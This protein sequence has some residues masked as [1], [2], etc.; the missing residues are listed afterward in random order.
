MATI[1]A[2]YT[3]HHNKFRVWT[4]T[5][6]GIVWTERPYLRVE[7]GDELAAPDI[8]GFLLSYRT[9]E[10]AAR[11][12]DDFGNDAIVAPEWF[13]ALDLNRHFVK[14]ELL[15]RNNDDPETGEPAILRTWYGVI[16][17]DERDE[18]QKPDESINRTGLQTLQVFGL[19]RLLET[20][21]INSSIVRKPDG[22]T[23]TIGRGLPFNFESRGSMNRRGNSTFAQ[24][25]GVYVFEYLP[26]GDQDSSNSDEFWNASD[27]VQY[28]LKHHRPVDQYGDSLCAWVA[29]PVVGGDLPITFYDITVET[30]RRSVKAVLDELIDRRRGVGYRVYGRETDSAF[31]AVLQVFTF[32]ATAIPLEGGEIPANESAEALFAG[33]S[34]I[35]DS[36]KVRQIATH[37]VDELIVEGAPPTSTFTLRVG[38]NAAEVEELVK[39]WT[40]QQEDDYRAGASGTAEENAAVR[41]RDALKDVFAR[42]VIATEW[43]TTVAVAVESSDPEEFWVALAQS[44][45]IP[46]DVDDDD[47]HDLFLKTDD[48]T[49]AGPLAF[50]VKRFLDLMPLKDDET[51]E[52]RRPF[53]VFAV[54][55]AG[56]ADD[57]EDI[58]AFAE[59]VSAITDEHFNCTT[60]MLPDRLGIHLEVNRPGGQQ[61]IAVDH[62]EDASETSADIDPN[63]AD[64]LHYENLRLTA[65]IEWDDRVTLKKTLNTATGQKRILRI[66]LP[67]M[68]LDFLLPGTVLDVGADSHL[69]ISTT[70]RVL[71]DDRARGRMILEAAAAWYGQ[72]RQAITISY[73]ELHPKLEIGTL[74]TR[75]WGVSDDPINT[76]VTGIHFNARQGTTTL[77][78]AYAEMDFSTFGRG[79]QGRYL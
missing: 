18:A 1:D 21:F 72:V 53:V 54:A 49:R 16:E 3:Y 24:E 7:A 66:S 22:D 28:L 75:L 15:D 17:L 58:W 13:N 30:D 59:N 37:Q 38:E 32:N 76:P 40:D 77:E 14:V 10:F 35:V 6:L 68:R 50:H 9:G 5:T 62:W 2:Y 8:D 41:S 44:V 12:A 71:K 23:H 11:E 29:E 47:V 70:G 60:K 74:L 46:D 42:F 52:F 79:A 39:G 34:T 63:S 78:T 64:G 69:E 51:N 33:A 55:D 65:T 31:E 27:A 56:E 4:S 45:T 73:R 67:D 26:R 20:T 36:V 43:P 25:D 19:L 61:M 57:A 48:P